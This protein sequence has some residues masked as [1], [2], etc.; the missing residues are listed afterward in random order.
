MK[1]QNERKE[2]RKKKAISIVEIFLMI[3]VSF[4]VAFSLGQ[5]FVSADVTS[6]LPVPLSK[7]YRGG[8]LP[9]PTGSA[10]G[11]AL[12]ADTFPPQTALS[13]DGV[14]VVADKTTG[15]VSQFTWDNP[16]KKIYSGQATSGVGGSLVAGVAWAAT[17]YIAVKLIGSFLG[18]K[19]GQQKALENAA[20]AGGFTAGFLSSAATNVPGL[21]G[22][23]TPGLAGSGG[24][25][26]FMTF[27]GGVPAGLIIA[28]AVFI[29]TYTDEKKEV[30]TYLC[31]PY[32]PPIK[33]EKCEQCNKDPFKPCSEYRC[34]AL[35]QACELV[36]KGTGHDKCVWVNKF[37]VK[38]PT[39]SP[40][41][42]ALTTG[43]KYDPDNSI[44]PPNRGVKIVNPLNQNGCL[45]AFTKLTFGITTNTSDENSEPARCKIDYT[46][47]NSTGK[48]GFDSMQYY[49]GGSNYFEYNHV[50]E[51]KL[52]SPNATGV[53]L[54]PLL[55]NG[56]TATLYVKCMD[57]NGNVN[58]DDF[59]FTFCVDKGPDTTPPIIEATSINNDA[60]VQYNADSVPIDVYVN[61][62]AECKW[63][64]I[65]KS[66]NDMEN[67]MN[68]ATKTYEVNSQ[69]TYTCSGSL[70]G[71]KNEQDNIFYFR[72]KDQPG[73][74]ENERYSMEQSYVLNLKG[75]RQLTLISLIPNETIRGNTEVVP[76]TLEV[77]TGAGAEEGKAVCYFSSTGDKDSYVAMFETDNYISR[78]TLDLT[79]SLAGIPYKYYVR[80][81]DAGGNA[82]EGS[83]GFTIFVDKNQPIV[84]RAYKEV[85]D[86]LKI[87][88]NEDAQC[89][90]SLNSCNYNFADGKQMLYIDTSVLNVHAAEWKN[91]A[92][93]YIKCKD[94]YENQPSPN[95]CSIVVSAIELTQRNA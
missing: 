67:N 2:I 82:A 60:Y 89:V 22:A 24:A 63:S 43:L 11:A 38:S 23:A 59:V 50:Q 79:G 51:M 71:I 27:G 6:L 42:S 64:R 40:L 20:L 73:K 72:C 36:D 21:F 31:L 33:G 15:G 69:L 48:A 18:L 52:P 62:P 78:Q 37:D 7:V 74:P 53:D 47:G 28:A 86:A 46:R 83:T 5:N 90:Y 65:D 66:F 14:I 80:C 34:K 76:V 3:S 25:L 92:Y 9:A 93:Y 88:T 17:A 85:P 68:C 32:E 58:E 95:A 55:K 94:K 61:E 4:A 45:Q 84:T 10:S 44:R 49:F 16:I 30:V 13:Q 26:N 54:G 56:E 8:P 87:V 75:S 12:G 77:Q 39:I 57:A 35:G 41:K 91:N 19:D 70:T 81:V 1:K 29:L